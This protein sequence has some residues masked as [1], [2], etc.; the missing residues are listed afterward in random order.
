MLFQLRF[1]F[2]ANYNEWGASVDG[3]AV[4]PAGNTGAYW[5]VETYA[6]VRGPRCWCLDGQCKLLTFLLPNNKLFLEI[7]VLEMFILLWFSSPSIWNSIQ[8]SFQLSSLHDL[9]SWVFL[10]SHWIVFRYLLLQVVFFLYNLLTFI[11]LKFLMVSS[12]SYDLI[13]F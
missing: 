1:R 7:K 6:Y 2:G 4:F 9:I 5:W 10:Q 11:V 3:W 8:Y 13:F 12:G